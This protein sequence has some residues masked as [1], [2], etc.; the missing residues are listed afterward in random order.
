MSPHIGAIIE[1]A[2]RA[3]QERARSG[4]RI[5]ADERCTCRPDLH[6]LKPSPGIYVMNY[7]HDDFCPMVGGTG[8]P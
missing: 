6:L 3:E 8:T 5:F 4:E 1:Q 2:Y 7:V